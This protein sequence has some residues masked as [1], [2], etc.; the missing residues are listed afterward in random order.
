LAGLLLVA[1]SLVFY[2]GSAPAK[3]FPVFEYGAL[4]Y[5]IFSAVKLDR[6]ARVAFGSRNS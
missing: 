2:G 1:M 4:A 5:L 6:Q 3:E